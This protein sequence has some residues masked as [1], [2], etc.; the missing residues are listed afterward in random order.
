[1]DRFE[2]VKLLG[3][4][5]FGAVNL[6][7]DRRDGRRYACKVMS[8]RTY[9]TWDECLKLREVRALR[10]LGSAHRH[11]VS[12]R[13]VI[14]DNK[15]LY[16]VFEYHPSTLHRR[17]RE[18]A[19]RGAHE[20]FPLLKI[21]QWSCQLLSAMA[22]MHRHGFFHRDVK[23]ENLLLDASDE[24]QV[25]DFGLARDVRSRPPY[26][27]Y[28][29]TRWYRAPE[30]VLRS[31][32]YSSPV[33]VWACACVIGEA[34]TLAPLFPAGDKLEHLLLISSQ[35]D[36]I[37]HRSWPQG[38][39]LALKQRLQLPK[40]AARKPLA[41]TLLA[42][43]QAGTAPGRIDEHE[44]TLA[45]DCVALLCDMMRLDPNQRLSAKECLAHPFLKPAY[46]GEDA[47][48][49]APQKDRGCH[50]LD[51]LEA[52]AQRVGDLEGED[53]CHQQPQPPQPQHQQPQH[54]SLPHQQ[55]L[56]LQQEQLEQ[57][58]DTHTSKPKGARDKD[59][60]LRILT[61]EVDDLAEELAH[62]GN[63][64]PPSSTQDQP[65]P[66]ESK[67]PAWSTEAR[68]TQGSSTKRTP[69]SE[70][71]RTKGIE[72][73]FG[74]Q[75][76]GSGGSSSADSRASQSTKTSPSKSRSLI[77]RTSSMERKVISQ[78]LSTLEDD[79]EEDELGG[80]AADRGKPGQHHGDAGAEDG[81]EQQEE[82][83][84]DTARLV[85]QRR[86]NSLRP[87]ALSHARR[88]ASK[89][90]ASKAKPVD[91]VIVMEELEPG[92]LLDDDEVRSPLR[93]ASENALGPRCPPG[94]AATATA[95]VAAAAKSPSSTAQENVEVLSIA[96]AEEQD[97]AQHQHLN[98]HHQQTQHQQ[99]HSPWTG[100]M[101]RS[102]VK[103]PAKSPPMSP[104][105]SPYRQHELVLCHV[106]RGEAAQELEAMRN[107]LAAQEAIIRRLESE[108]GSLRK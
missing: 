83:D 45:K 72:S 102:P 35:V 68:A 96:S 38:Y 17:I 8:N 12:L 39:T 2:C 103:S 100:S 25:C 20:R 91:E 14:R 84:F 44:L 98:D 80:S 85:G 76:R 93:A 3:Q 107:R 74:E 95:A 79:E 24:I 60:A 86:I 26:T 89:Q 82:E 97:E 67:V 37:T 52:A 94:K 41:A 10:R 1:M 28:V 46:A 106:C 73:K 61:K 33:D 32:V 18:L 42:R 87:P 62:I 104:L 43:F 51:E 49:H 5:A 15:K 29:S 65:E 23:P 4:G 108:L 48:L 55:Q 19:A 27:D 58:T 90:D 99:I 21:A 66:L 6:V 88:A 101:I 47:M 11:I 40:A 69:T 92:A 31:D 22:Y 59:S 56:Q 70:N 36:P 16:L 63:T 13:Q 81:K 7:V 78:Y 9:D 64:S 54:Q 30:L 50:N 77:T 57:P 53:E 105:S 71:K 75:G 34:L